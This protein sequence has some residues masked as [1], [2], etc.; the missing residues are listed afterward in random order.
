MWFNNQELY[1]LMNVIYSSNEIRPLWSVSILSKFHWTISSVMVRFKGLKVSSISLLNSLISIRS[2]YSPSLATFFAFTARSPKKWA[3]YILPQIHIHRR[4]SCRHCRC[5]CAWSASRVGPRKYL[6][7][8]PPSCRQ[9]AL[10]AQ[11]AQGLSS[12]PCRRLWRWA[13]TVHR[14]VIWYLG[15]GLALDI[16]F[17]YKN[18]VKMYTVS[19][20]KWELFYPGLYFLIIFGRI[21]Q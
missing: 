13:G 16:W 11:E 7:P 6:P 5:Q 10:W 17:N 3:N 1:F 9:E 4:L 8:W 2:S 12:D 19:H 20:P 15:L 14:W 18:E 21:Y